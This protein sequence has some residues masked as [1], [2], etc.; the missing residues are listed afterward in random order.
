MISLDDV[1]FVLKKAPPGTNHDDIVPWLFRDIFSDEKNICFVKPNRSKNEILVKT[2]GGVRAVNTDEFIKLFVNTIFLKKI[3]YF[4][5]HD[6]FEFEKYLSRNFI[7]GGVNWGG[8]YPDGNTYTNLFGK[9]VILSPTFIL[10]MRAVVRDFLA[11][12][13]DRMQIKNTLLNI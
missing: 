1:T 7:V 8:K 10:S 3:Y 2:L 11:T 13:N 5:I 9:K 4:I 6:D 12:Q